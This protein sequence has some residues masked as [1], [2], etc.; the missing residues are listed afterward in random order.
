MSIKSHLV[1]LYSV[2]GSNMHKDSFKFKEA[3]LTFMLMQFRHR[4]TSSD[5]YSD[6]K[7]K[8]DIL[9]GMNLVKDWYSSHMYG[10]GE[11]M[12]RISLGCCHR[13]T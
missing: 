5:E 6:Y 4:P 11:Q 8:F 12:S 10:T 1:P 2:E 9:G 3:L 7:E 13:M